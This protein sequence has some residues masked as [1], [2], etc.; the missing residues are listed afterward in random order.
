MNSNKR[1][2]ALA[3][4]LTVFAASCAMEGQQ[5]GG[6]PMSYFVT[7]AGSGNGADLGGLAGADRLCQSRAQAVGAGNK[8]WRA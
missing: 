1:K 6:N 5:G 2:V 8:T 7:S 3:L 4:G